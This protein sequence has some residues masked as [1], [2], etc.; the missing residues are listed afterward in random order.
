MM[1][2]P[3]DIV[4]HKPYVT[5]DYTLFHFTK[6]NR[7]IVDSHVNSLI[8]D[9]TIEDLHYLDPI[10]VNSEMGITSGQ[11]RFL[12]R[13]KLKLPVYYFVRDQNPTPGQIQQLSTRTLKWK[14]GDV[15]NSHC[16]AGNKDYLLV[17]DFIKIHNIN[18]STALHVID[19]RNAKGEVRVKCHLAFK[20]GLFRIKDINEAGERI[21]ML[22]E[23]GKFYP[24]WQRRCFVIA[25]L[26]I[27]KLPVYKHKRLLEKLR[28]LSIKM[29]D[30]T[31]TT[32]YVK[33]IEGIYN[34]KQ[35]EGTKVRFI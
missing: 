6:G 13:R 35:G 10:D 3:A 21:K 26:R 32:S 15:L 16:K 33:M 12:A 2:K 20:R 18:L 34:N 23:I 9:M 8:A 5:S 4:C 31:D 28:Y 17:R 27:F 24:N 30:C 29:V 14:Q 22:K 25:M 19:C 11:H 7:D 1:E